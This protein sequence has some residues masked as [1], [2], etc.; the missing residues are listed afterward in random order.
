MKVKGYSTFDKLKTCLVGRTYS[1][2]QFREIK[3]QKVKD[4]LFKILDETEEDYQNLCDVLN[5][6]GV[7]TLR[8]DVVETDTSHRPANQPRD[9][10]AVI[11]LL[12][13]SPSPRD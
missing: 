7:E 9:D 11:C 2:E 12:Y 4:I 13:T 1:K 3:N 5:K 10:M 6:A 8:P